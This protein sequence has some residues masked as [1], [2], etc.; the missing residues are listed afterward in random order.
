MDKRVIHRIIKWFNDKP[1]PPFRLM[2]SITS[3]C[4]LQCKFCDKRSV[5]KKDLLKDSEILF[6]IKE[7]K[8]LGIKEV[9]IS[10][11][12]EPFMRKNILRKT[13][14]EIKKNCMKGVV[15]TNGTLLE[16]KDI[17]MLIKIRWDEVNFSLDGYRADIHDSLRGV[18]GSFKKT[19]ETIRLLSKIKKVR[20][21]HFPS[22][23]ISTLI[24]NK[25][26]TSI[27]KFISLCKKLDVNKILFQYIRET[28][29]EASKLRIN[30]KEFDKYLKKGIELAERFN[31]DTNLKDF[32]FFKKITSMKKIENV[33][34]ELTCKEHKLLV[35][36]CYNPWYV[37]TVN[38]EGKIG[39]CPIWASKSEINVF[40]Y[41]LKEAWEGEYFSIIRK[42]MLL[43]DT[44]E[45]RCGGP[46]ISENKN[47]RM[48]LEKLYFSKN[49]KK[50]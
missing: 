13:M 14:K 6:L 11:G 5:K 27:E 37:I 41:S 39:P 31:F 21:T 30:E 50:T 44:R 17:E 15:V 49:F 4:N 1:Q 19:V 29:T 24:T 38:D 20:G 47:I 22:I 2:L 42:K 28:T 7:A 26:Y 32:M 35:I 12:G 43:N 18:K 36:P 46:S 16:R 3:K 48:E 40:C 45:C 10:G 8:N 34:R 9:H 25:N 33:I 23:T